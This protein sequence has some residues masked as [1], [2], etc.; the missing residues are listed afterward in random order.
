MTKAVVLG[1]LNADL[2]ADVPRT[3]FEGESLLAESFVVVPGGKGANQASTLSRLGA[4]VSMLGAVGKDGYGAMLK[5]SLA[6]AGVDHSHLDERDDI[7]T[8]VA[9][10]A[11]C[12]NGSNSIISVLGANNRVDCDYIDR[13]IDLL[14]EC[15]VFVLQLE[16]P[17]EAAA[18][19][20]KKAKEFGKLVVLDPAP[21][22]E[23][24][25]EGLLDS[26]DLVK[27]NEVEL[28][29][30]TGIPEAENHLEEAI[31]TLK[32]MGAKD[33]L[34]TLGSKG[35]CVSMP[36]GSIHI[37]EAKKVKAVDTTAAGDAFTASVAIKLAEGKSLR[38]AAEF[39]T[40]VSAIVV[41]RKGAQS[42]I[43]TRE[44]LEI[45]L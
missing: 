25:P 43:P 8:G 11:V 21:A 36:D 12:P 3:P 27:P 23:K 35:S 26:V 24:L 18:Y 2:V 38:E 28:S 20:A 19:A 37:I 14:K 39:A 32:Q 17:L 22:P 13:N 9:M 15:D 34:V 1:S 40:S 41:T 5:E 33:V 44:E 29:I 6:K 45:L 42:S 4:E 30:L 16:V 31:G 7:S 10:I